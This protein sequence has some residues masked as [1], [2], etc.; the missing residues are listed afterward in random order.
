MDLTGEQIIEMLEKSVLSENLLQVSGMRIVYD[1]SKPSGVKVAEAEVAGKP[2][3]TQKTYKVVTTDF[4][5]TRGGPFKVFKQGRNVT[6]GPP[7]RDAVADHISKHSPINA[8]PLD[9][10]VF[11]N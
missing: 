8:K 11:K 9:R 10:I 2:M 5:A 1:L 3:E 7:V 6:F 4:L